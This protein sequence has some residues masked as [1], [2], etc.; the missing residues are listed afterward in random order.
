MENPVQV[1][2]LENGY[3]VITVKKSKG[4]SSFFYVNP[5]EKTLIPI[6]KSRKLAAD[7][8]VQVYKL[9]AGGAV[10]T[11]K[12]LNTNNFS[13][14][15]F[16]EDQQ[17]AAGDLTD[18]DSSADEAAT[19]RRRHRMP[20]GKAKRVTVTPEAT[21]ATN[22]TEAGTAAAVTE[23]TVTLVERK[24]AGR[25]APIVIGAAAA[26]FVGAGAFAES[27]GGEPIGL[28]NAEAK[29]RFLADYAT[30]LDHLGR[31]GAADTLHHLLDLLAFVAE[32][33]PPVVWDRIAA[34][35]IGGGRA[36]PAARTA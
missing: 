34:V 5:K 1:D 28:V 29:R 33:N 3:A 21:E 24:A 15:T 10:I 13:L 22:G 36:T 19:S 23:A 31:V 11:F 16:Y 7:N 14:A 6:Y 35:L 25:R 17:S 30:T 26:T 9:E 32:A 8:P 12:D 27:Q 4:N 18:G 20:V 2:S